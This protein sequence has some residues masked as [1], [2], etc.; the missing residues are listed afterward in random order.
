MIFKV[1]SDEKFSYVIYFDIQHCSLVNIV[2]IYIISSKI[3]FSIQLVKV[4]DTVNPIFTLSGTEGLNRGL[5][6]ASKRTEGL[7]PQKSRDRP[8]PSRHV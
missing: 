7:G 4:Q 1:I 2:I 8:H 5:G 3:W 6:L